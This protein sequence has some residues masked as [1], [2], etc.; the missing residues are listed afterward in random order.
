LKPAFV[1][2]CGSDLHE[3]EDGPHIIPPHGEKH[4]MTGEGPPLILGHEF[5]AVVDEVGD[6]VK[7]FKPG[8]KVAVQP[9]IYDNSCRACSR[10]LT[11]SC[12][13]FGFIGLSGWGGGMSEYTTA[14]AEY[15]KKLPDDMDLKIGALVEPL[16]VG[17]HAVSTSPYKDGDSV[18][19]LGGG[20]IGLAVILALLAKGCKTVICAEV[21]RNHPLRLYDGLIKGN[22]F[23]ND[24]ESSRRISEH[25]TLLIQ[26]TKT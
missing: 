2:I 7:D 1:G 4:S 19:V 16:A 5:S 8:D 13:S 18:L 11:N 6:G 23:R 3:Y 15:L 25:S 20:P 9:T 22:R 17:W 24:E 26:P 14:P 10:G 21:S 12:D